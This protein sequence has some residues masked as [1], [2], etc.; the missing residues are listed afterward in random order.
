MDEPSKD[1]TN[2][3][4]PAPQRRP[5]YGY[6]NLAREDPNRDKRYEGKEGLKIRVN[7]DLALDLDIKLKGEIYG[8]LIIGLITSED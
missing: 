7:A 2:T 5:R 6:T 3:N 4:K 8:D 1:P